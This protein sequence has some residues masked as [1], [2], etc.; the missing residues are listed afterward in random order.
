MITISELFTENKIADINPIKTQ[1]ILGVKESTVGKVYSA[2]TDNTY[3]LILE[4]GELIEV[5]LTE[6]SLLTTN[7]LSDSLLNHLWKSNLEFIQENS[8]FIFQSANLDSIA[9]LFE[10]FEE[11][12]AL[13]IDKH[14]FEL[15]TT[16]LEIL[17][18]QNKARIYSFL[19]WL[20][21]ISRTIDVDHS[22]F[23]FISKIGEPSNVSKSLP[24]IYLYK[25]EIEYLRRHRTIDSIL[26]FLNFIEEKVQDHA[27]T[28]YLKSIYLKALIQSPSYWSKHEQLF[29][30]DVLTTVLERE[31]NNQYGYLLDSPLSSFY[32]SQNGEEAY[33]FSGI[34]I[35]GKRISLEEFDGKVI[36]MD[37]WA[38]WCGPC[39]KHR[40]NVID[41]AKK[42][43]NNDDVAI[44]MVSVDSDYDRWSSFMKDEGITPGTNLFI[45]NGMRTDFGDN[46][47]IKSIP[48]YI[49]VGK[50]G[51]IVDSN[52][53]EPSLASE[54]AIEKALQQ[55]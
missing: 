48:R 37:V 24:D 38:T 55:D 20:G 23:D 40:S 17:H 2:E 43:Q 15:T 27:L 32:K 13:L 49:L 45:E 47:N 34:D 4:P 46:Y 52:M 28:D 16:E 12:R 9:H 39:L 18:F 35:Q 21:R 29:T 41:L 22:Y 26:Q 6:D 1:E 31:K 25:Y 8:A 36:Y 3:L 10:H 11:Q 53:P 42:Y 33:N 50:N 14:K 7:S 51:K 44:L 30:S 54:K 19:F 5:N